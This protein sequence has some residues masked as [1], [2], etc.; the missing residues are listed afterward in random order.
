MDENDALLQRIDDT[1]LQEA[2]KDFFARRS[3]SSPDAR[4]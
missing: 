3:A 4:Q 2:L 1:E